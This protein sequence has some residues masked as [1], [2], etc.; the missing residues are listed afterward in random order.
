MADTTAVS[1]CNS[2]LM[3]LGVAASNFITALSDGTRNSDYCGQAYD[4]SLEQELR[5]HNWNFAKSRVKLSEAD[6][7]TWAV[8]QEGTHVFG[9]AAA[10]DSKHAGLLF[11]NTAGAQMKQVRINVA[12]FTASGI[13]AAKIYTD[14]SGSPAVQVG[15]DSDSQTISATG[16][17]KF[18]WSS[19]IPALAAGT[20]YWCIVSNDD[21]TTLNVTLDDVTDQ[22]ANYA[23]GKHDTLTSIADASGTFTAADEWRFEVLLEP[24][25]GFDFLY[26]LPSDYLRVVAAY[27][28][29]ADT[30]DMRYELVDGK[31]ATNSN[32]VF[33]TYIRDEATVTN[34]DPLF[35][36]ALVFRIARKLAVPVT[37]S[38]TILA[39]MRQ[40]YNAAIR[41][42]RSVDAIEDYPEQFP[43]SSWTAA[44]RSSRSTDWG[45]GG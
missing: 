39:E 4:E 22:G 19:N 31:L 27:D 21:D 15:G 9:D 14:V 24:L 8:A 12:A 11:L 7:G 36:D 41:R 28:S 35:R 33:L 18:T 2:A 45:V 32:Q 40:E 43:E 1:L 30:G 6:M 42:A 20:S 10:A 25:S 23:S 37:G 29:D 5:A 17:V 26:S 38:R 44:R 34:F 13:A 3:E 16:E